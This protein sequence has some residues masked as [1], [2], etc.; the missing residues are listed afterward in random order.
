MAGELHKSGISGTTIFHPFPAGS[1][2]VPGKDG[3]TIAH[4]NDSVLQEGK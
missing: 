1:G 4:C 2:N 3:Q